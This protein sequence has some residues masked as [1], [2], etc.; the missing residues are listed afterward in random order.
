[1]PCKIPLKDLSCGEQSIML[2]VGSGG[3]ERGLL[4]WGMPQVNSYFTWKSPHRAV[5]A[6]NTHLLLKSMQLGRDQDCWLSEITRDH[7]NQ[8]WNSCIVLPVWWCMEVSCC[9][10][11]LSAVLSDSFL[12]CCFSLLICIIYNL[13][14]FI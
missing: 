10:L 5:Q 6:N 7:R 11:L 4:I 12:A 1:M 9:T 2:T 8:V 3:T 13:Y 14:Y